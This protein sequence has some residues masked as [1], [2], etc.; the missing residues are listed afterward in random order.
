MLGRL[1]MR[2]AG[3]LGVVAEKGREFFRAGVEVNE[4][5]ALI[6]GVKHFVP[7]PG[8]IITIGGETFG[9]IL[10]DRQG[11]YHKYI[12]NSACAAGTGSFLDQQASRLGLSGSEELSRIGEEYQGDP[13]RIATRCAV[14]A[15]T[16][17]VHMQQ[18]GY[19]LP[20]IAAGLARGVAQNI[21]DT[22]FHGVELLDPVVAA[23]G[24]VKNRKVLQ[25]LQEAVGRPLQALTDG[26]YIGAIGAAL[27]ASHAAE[28]RGNSFRG[29]CPC[30][31]LNEPPEPP[32]PTD[33]RPCRA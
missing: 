3:C 19:G 31:A 32:S 20:A 15:R 6:A 26:E 33:T 17:L 21:Y 8:A 24:V 14:F 10:F 11:H 5:V 18:Q 28:R 2:Q 27:I 4:Q 7:N 25:Y 13:P 29:P 12:T 23:G 1:P 30:A 16:D 9:L 22:L